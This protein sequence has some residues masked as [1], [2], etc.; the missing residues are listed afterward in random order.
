MSSSTTNGSESLAL[1]TRELQ[2]YRN[3]ALSQIAQD[4]VTGKQAFDKKVTERLTSDSETES[5]VEQQ[6]GR[7]FLQEATQQQREEFVKAM[8]PITP[9]DYKSAEGSWF[10]VILPCD[11]SEFFSRK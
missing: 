7:L 9:E 11:E 3:A 8:R 5:S 2:S 4:I 10:T 6:F 1:I